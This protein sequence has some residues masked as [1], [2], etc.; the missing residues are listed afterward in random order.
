MMRLKTRTENKKRGRQKISSKKSSQVWLLLR[1]AVILALLSTELLAAR[2]SIIDVAGT[3]H[4]DLATAG[5]ALGM[6]AVWTKTGQKVELRSKWTTLKFEVDA[7]DF[8]LNNRKIYLGRPLT[9]H[10]GRPL[11]TQKDFLL[12]IRPI[13]APQ[14]LARKPVLRRVVIDAGHGGRDF[15]AQNTSQSLR[16]K[17]LTLDVA[18]RLK[19][20]LESDGFQVFLTRKNDTYIPLDQRGDFANRMHADLFISIHFNSVAKVDVRG[21]ETYLLPQPW[22]ASTSRSAL[23]PMDKQ[24]YPGNKDDG[25]N[26]LVGFYVHKTLVERLAVV[27]RGLKRSRF[28]VL[29]NLGCPGMLV[30]LGFISHKNTAQLL[31]QSQYREKLA[32]SLAKG[33]QLYRATQ[34][35]LG[36]KA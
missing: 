29:K 30:E 5:K 34:K 2:L 15:G 32:I 10:K 24:T 27:D 7:R 3:P 28:K 23:E 33:I 22:T 12:T 11:I 19:R 17:D 13:L 9:I 31:R 35:R 18:F 1:S 36:G 20:I 14:T 6:Q 21:L 8:V 4:Y 16:E 25:W 26:S